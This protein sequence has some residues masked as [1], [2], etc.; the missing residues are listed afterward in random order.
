MKIRGHEIAVCS[1]S[2][3]PKDMQDLV[4]ALKQLGLDAIQLNLG[5]LLMLDDKR[6]HHE[7]GIL[8]ANNINIV[9]GMCGF[10]GEDYSSIAHIR[11]TGG[12]MPD[13][14]WT[15]RRQLSQQAA[16]LAAELGIEKTSTHIGFVP[17]SNDEKYR[18]MLERVGEVAQMFADKNQKLLFETGQERAP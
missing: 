11:K 16:N 1:W 12:Y 3:H 4:D 9:A 2:V 15:L 14:Q 13:D 8:R 6:K 18:V 7:L 5:A 17:P 10:P